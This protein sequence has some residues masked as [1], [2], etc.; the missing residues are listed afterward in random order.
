[1]R[2]DQSTFCGHFIRWVEP[3]TVVKSPR[4]GAI[5]IQCPQSQ[6]TGLYSI[7]YQYLTVHLNEPYET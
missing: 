5:D 2:F 6:H 1:M 3:T 4:S 7:Y